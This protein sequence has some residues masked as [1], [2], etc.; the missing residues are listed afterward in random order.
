FPEAP[1]AWAL[2]PSLALPLGA[3]AG[4][5]PDAAPDPGAAVVPGA[6]GAVPLGIVPLLALPPGTGTA[7]LTGC[8]GRNV[9]PSRSANPLPSVGFF[10]LIASDHNESGASVTVFAALTHVIR[11]KVIHSLSGS[12]RPSLQPQIPWPVGLSK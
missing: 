9:C 2:A 8:S 12:T 7:T 11:A 6:V 3:F 4:V 10:W 5:K 1:W